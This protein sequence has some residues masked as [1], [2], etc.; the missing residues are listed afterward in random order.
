[1][2]PVLEFGVDQ[3]RQGIVQL[4]R[5]IRNGCR[6]VDPH[7]R[8]SHIQILQHGV[9]GVHVRRFAVAGGLG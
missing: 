5:R 8:F 3:G 7:V 1:M 6:R 4:T 2:N 9:E